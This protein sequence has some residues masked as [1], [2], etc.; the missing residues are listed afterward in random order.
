MKNRSWYVCKFKSS[1]DEQTKVRKK[2]LV[3]MSTGDDLVKKKKDEG[4]MIEIVKFDFQLKHYKFCNI[5]CTWCG[6]KYFF[7]R[8]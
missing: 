3:V 6:K 4:E 5:I 2:D 8:I 1:P 7:F